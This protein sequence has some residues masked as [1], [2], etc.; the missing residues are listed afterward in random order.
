MKAKRQITEQEVQQAIRKF[1]S[2]GGLIK[3]LDKE[4]TPR[5]SLV[6]TKFG[7]YEP[8][9]EYTTVSSDSVA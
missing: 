3:H 8:V 7:M 9:F 6:G 2:E 5:S 1:L 4:P